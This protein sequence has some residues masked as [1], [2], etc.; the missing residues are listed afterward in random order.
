MF[1]ELL[2]PA[3]HPD[4]QLIDYVGRVWKGIYPHSSRA[5][6]ENWRLAW[7]SLISVDVTVC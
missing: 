5:S 7:Q 1:I 6:E 4:S 2:F 3:F